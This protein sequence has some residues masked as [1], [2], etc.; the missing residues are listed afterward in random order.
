MSI[1]NRKNQTLVLPAHL[2]AD[3]LDRDGRLEYEAATD[4]EP[5]R[6]I[7][8]GAR[9]VAMRVAPVVVER[10]GYTI[11]VSRSPF[12]RAQVDSRSPLGWVDAYGANMEEAI[13]NALA[14]LYALGGEAA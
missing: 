7:K 4:V 6:I 14:R 3:S 5:L 8:P 11:E 2:S 12:W 1:L 9:D 13:E 10:D